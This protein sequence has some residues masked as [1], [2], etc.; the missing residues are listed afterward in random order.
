VVNFKRLSSDFKM[1]K[2]SAI[3]AAAALLLVGCHPDPTIE[4]DLQQV[5]LNFNMLKKEGKLPGLSAGEPAE[6]SAFLI[7]TKARGEEWFRSFSDVAPECIALYLLNV[8]A[9][10]KRLC[11]FICRNNGTPHL[12]AAFEKRSGN[13]S[14]IDLR[15]DAVE[16]RERNRRDPF[17]STSRRPAS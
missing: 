13:W 12:V 7:D 6:V 4:D 8:N 10:G 3:I 9:S 1:R 16:N 14:R 2:L 17:Q 5:V 15:N 11:Y